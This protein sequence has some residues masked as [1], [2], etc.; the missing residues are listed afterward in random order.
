MKAGFAGKY[1]IQEDTPRERV[2]PSDTSILTALAARREAKRL[3]LLRAY[4]EANTREPITDRSRID[5][6]RVKRYRLR[7]KL[8]LICVTVDVGPD[9]LAGLMRSGL[10]QS[11]AAAESSEIKAALESFLAANL[12]RT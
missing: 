8:G 4:E 10:L 3:K 7:R 1:D 11:E 9:H 6:D 12:N 5:A 2:D